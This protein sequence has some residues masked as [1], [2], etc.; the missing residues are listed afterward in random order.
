MAFAVGLG[1]INIHSSLNQQLN[2]QV[3]IVDI[4]SVPLDSVQVK[5]A[6][7]D[8]F[9]LVGLARDP[10]LSLLRFNVLRAANGQAYVQISST[11]PVAAPVVTF[12]VNLTWPNG[13]M[14]REYTV[15]LDPVSYTH[16]VST[17]LKPATSEQPPQAQ[18][19]QDNN[20]E[21]VTYGPTTSQDDL[22]E[23]AKKTR[24]KN[25]SIQ[26]NMVA[27]FKKN[28]RAFGH[29]SIN[30]LR[31]GYILNLP[32]LQQVKAISKA[33]AVNLLKQQDKVSHEKTQQQTQQ[34]VQTLQEPLTAAPKQQANNST[35][36]EEIQLLPESQL[37]EEGNQLN[38]SATTKALGSESITQQ[39]TKTVLAKQLIDMQKQLIAK[40]RQ[41]LALEKVL[42]ENQSPQQALLAPEQP[43]KQSTVAMPEQQTQ[44]ASQAGEIKIEYG[45]PWYTF[46]LLLL[47]VFVSLLLGVFIQRHRIKMGYSNQDSGNRL[48]IPKVIKRLLDRK[49]RSEPEENAFETIEK[50]STS[51]TILPEP[52]DNASSKLDLMSSLPVIEKLI[53]Q[54]DYQQAIERLKTLH[55]KNETQ[56]DINLKLLELYGLAQQKTE[57]KKCYQNLLDSGLTTTQKNLLKSIS[58]IFS[59]T[60][61]EPET[62]EKDF[63]NV[64]VDESP[65]AFAI[66]TVQA[67]LEPEEDTEPS[68]EKAPDTHTIEFD[69]SE[70]NQAHERQPE[71]KEEPETIDEQVWSKMLDNL[72]MT[73]TE[74]SQLDIESDNMPDSEDGG[75]LDIEQSCDSELQ[76]EVSRPVRED[77]L[78]S[79][80]DTPEP[81][82]EDF[83]MQ[84][85]LAT[86]YIE[87]GDIQEA[88]DILEHIVAQAPD[89]D[90]QAA[91]SLL[92]QL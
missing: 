57:F 63:D 75:E 2:A 14:M 21:T 60:L 44:S 80:S 33:D 88:K 73:P 55:D 35:K 45:L 83:E 16:K 65:E 8:Q 7:V 20:L 72:S 56:F 23:V 12:L 34:S 87:M 27:I 32:T 68:K 48:K 39:K 15:F 17:Q 59:E 90:K 37:M 18:Q 24:L 54:K 9:K 62:E 30:Q 3:S 67:V 69:T 53:G 78:Q 50:E 76:A 74:N 91:K 41:I 82:I 4:G 89:K 11:E 5:L 31:A 58:S 49:S 61:D 28:K 19:A 52:D 47:I 92:E 71:S 70:L 40:D 36:P 25:T 22:W 38:P 43:A 84:L 46:P 85:N 1:K 77:N 64:I 86:A 66:D 6:S 26:Q 29:E 42:E 51:K 79:E 13:Q 10:N 81:E